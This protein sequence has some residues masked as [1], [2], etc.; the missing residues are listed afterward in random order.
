MIE[1]WIHSRVN[2][3]FSFKVIPILNYFWYFL[4]SSL[5]NYPKKDFE[6]SNHQPIDEALPLTGSASQKWRRAVDSENGECCWEKGKVATVAGRN[7]APVDMIQDSQMQ[8]YCRW[9]FATQIVFNV[10]RDP[11]GWWSNLASIFFRWVGEK[12]PTRSIHFFKYLYFLVFLVS[13]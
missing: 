1:R 3:F 4:I 11:C 6:A 8:T 10:H 9:L 5:K 2:P 7:P 13:P 12:P